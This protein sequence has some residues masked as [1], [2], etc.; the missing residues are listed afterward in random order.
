MDKIA[1]ERVS[2]VK[3]FGGIAAVAAAAAADHPHPQSNATTRS[4]HKKP[5]NVRA[6]REKA[7][8]D[9][10]I[11]KNYYKSSYMPAH[12]AQNTAKPGKGPPQFVVEQ[13]EDIMNLL[14]P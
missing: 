4:V 7:V 11:Q 6:A 5:S 10:P 12:I 13:N 1:T 3:K 8:K 14:E 2:S 9:Q